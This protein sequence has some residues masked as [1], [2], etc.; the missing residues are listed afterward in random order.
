M[1]TVG[2]QRRHQ[3]HD[4]R[5]LLHTHVYP[6]LLVPHSQVSVDA[7]LVDLADHCHVRHAILRTCTC[8]MYLVNK[9]Q[10]DLSLI[11]YNAKQLVLDYFQ[12][13]EF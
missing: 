4:F 7:I 11:N 10:L 9:L 6:A 1:S 8:K 2:E 12:A 13:C 3:Q 5:L